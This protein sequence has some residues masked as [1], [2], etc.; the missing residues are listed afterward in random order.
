MDSFSCSRYPSSICDDCTTVAGQLGKVWKLSRKKLPPSAKSLF[1]ELLLDLRLHI[2]PADILDAAGNIGRAR[3]DIRGITELL[4]HVAN[5][6][7]TAATPPPP[8][9]QTELKSAIQCSDFEAFR[10][11]LYS[12]IGIGSAT[13]LSSSP[14]PSDLQGSSIGNTTGHVASMPNHADTPPGDILPISAAEATPEGKC[15]TNIPEEYSIE[16]GVLMQVPLEKRQT[17]FR[18]LSLEPQLP[19]ETHSEAVL[20]FIKFVRTANPNRSQGNQP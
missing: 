11:E 12:G 13:A 17:L 4:Q 18:Q 15:C 16:H 10:A 2:L 3:Y 9:M 7:D 19:N 5:R 20:R 14:G 6:R 1:A 8:P